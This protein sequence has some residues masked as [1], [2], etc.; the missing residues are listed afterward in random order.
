MLVLKWLRDR[1][2]IVIDSELWESVGGEERVIML[3]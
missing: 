1:G 2:S 3:N